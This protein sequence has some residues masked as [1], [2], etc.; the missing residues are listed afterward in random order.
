MTFAVGHHIVGIT[1]KANVLQVLLPTV[2]NWVFRNLSGT[3]TP[4]GSLLVVTVTR[5]WPG[6]TSVVLAF[7]GDLHALRPHRYA[8]WQPHP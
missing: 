1:F 4:E 3:F 2:Q 7:S 5:N 8:I 6:H